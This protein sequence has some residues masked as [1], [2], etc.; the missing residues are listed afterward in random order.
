MIKLQFFFIIVNCISNMHLKVQ[1]KGPRGINNTPGG[2]EP[3]WKQISPWK[4]I[5]S[6]CYKTKPLWWTWKNIDFGFK[7]MSFHY[8]S[9]F[10]VL[11]LCFLSKQRSLRNVQ[12]ICCCLGDYILKWYHFRG[13]RKWC[14]IS[15]SQ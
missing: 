9:H 8:F 3:K 10:T 6:L 2:A 14:Q 1:S 15:E 13:S 12:R 7:F 11:H 4:V 5:V